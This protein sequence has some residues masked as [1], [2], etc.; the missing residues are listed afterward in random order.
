M[1]KWVFIFCC[2]FLHGCEKDDFC[3]KKGT[4]SLV[5]SFYD[6]NNPKQKKG[7]TLYVWEHT[8]KDTLYKQVF[9][10]SMLLPLNTNTDSVYYKISYQNEVEHLILKYKTKEKFVSV[11]C[12]FKMDFLDLQIKTATQ[13]HWLL[14][15]RLV[16]KKVEDEAKAHIKIYH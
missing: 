6:E 9:L 1:F 12:G 3:D 15:A 2:V 10:D 13:K 5:L 4:P 14:N 7:L 16:R 8:Q 11:S